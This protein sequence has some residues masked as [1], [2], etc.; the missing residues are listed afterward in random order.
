MQRKFILYILL[1]LSF[2][3]QISNMRFVAW[4]PDFSLIILIYTA[5]FLGVLNGLCM[6]FV[7]GI[8]RGFFSPYM[9]P[10]D[11]VLFPVCALIS[12]I[13]ASFLFRQ[14]SLVQILITGISFFLIIS[15]HFFYL[16]IISGN[17]VG[18]LMQ[19]ADYWR[20]IIMTLLFS[21]LFINV[22][23][24]IEERRGII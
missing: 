4:L 6:G 24:Q 23:N 10:L 20:T 15:V 1:I 13:L 19:I 18:F 21:P 12:S 17:N 11:V 22:F 9:F 7:L 16:N 3:M 2:L 14:S 8:L 5:M